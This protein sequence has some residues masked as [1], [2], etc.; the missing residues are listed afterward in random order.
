M[1]DRSSCPDFRDFDPFR[2]QLFP[3]E[4]ENLSRHIESCPRC[5]RVV[6]ELMAKDTL[7]EGVS[8]DSA[9]EG[10]V[11]NA[12]VKTLIARL[13]ARPP[14]V[15][16]PSDDPPTVELGEAES[17]HACRSSSD[18][19]AEEMYDFLRPAL[20]SNRPVPF[21][22]YRVVGVLGT[23][24]M[25]IVLKAEDPQL[26]RPV[27]I[28]VLNPLLASNAMA[29]R[30]FL[31][32]ARAAAAL[33]HDHI[34]PIYHVGT[35]RG[36]PYLVMPMLSGETL[37]QRFRREGS[38]PLAEILR[39]GREVAAGLAAAHERGLVHRD[40][41]PS[42]LWLEAAGPEGSRPQG[43]RPR[44][45]SGRVRI[46]DFGLA[47]VEEEDG[48]L[49][50]EGHP[51]GTPAYMAPEQARGEKVGPGADLFSLGCIL[52]RL[53]TGKA[54]FRGANSRMLFRSLEEHLPRAP[55]QLNPALPA[56]FSDLLLR[57]LAKE[58]ADRPASA[59]EVVRDIA[60]IEQ[61]LAS[62]EPSSQRPRRR[63]RAVLAGVATLVLLT[64][65]A[66]GYQYAPSIYRL[67][68]DQG[69][70]V[71]ET[72]E[73]GVEVVIKDGTGRVIDHAGKREI[74]L[75]AGTYEVDCRLVDAGGEQQFLTKHL[76][77]RR[78]ERIVLDAR[79]E[80]AKLDL[81]GPA[82]KALRTLEAR[83]ANSS[84]DRE[85][86]R[87]QLLTFRRNYAGTPFGQRASE[88]LS[89]LTS[90]LDKLSAD[91]IP[92][93]ERA[94]AGGKQAPHELVAVLGSSS[95]G[96]WHEVHSVAFSP[97]GK[98]LAS[99][100]ADW[101]VKVWHVQN[102][103]ELHTLA[104]HQGYVNGVAFSPDG[105]TLASASQDGTVRIWD[106]ASG[107]ELQVLRGG[108]AGLSSVAFHRDGNLLASGSA[109]GS[110][111][112]WDPASG[113]ELGRLIGHTG[114]VYA[115]AFHPQGELLASASADRTVRL[116]D[117]RQFRG[118]QEQKGRQPEVSSQIP[119]RTLTGHGDIVRSVAFS[120]DG[121]LLASGSQDGTIL[122]WDVPQPAGPVKDTQTK[123]GVLTPR[124]LGKSRDVQA[125]AFSSDG[126]SLVTGT[127][128]GEKAE[129]WDIA[130][131]AVRYSVPMGHGC[132][133]VAFSPDDKLLAGGG[134][135]AA[136]HI[137]EPRMTSDGKT[138]PREWP[139]RAGL[140]PSGH[141]GIVSSVAFS[142]DGSTLA[143][144]GWD[145]TV[146]LCDC[147]S[148]Q[149][150]RALR[151]HQRMVASV[152]FSPDGKVLASSA[153][154]GSIRLWDSATGEKLPD[155]AGHP[156]YVTCLAFHPSGQF[157][158]S[159]SRDL[160]VKVW[161]LASRVEHCTL[162]S[163]EKLVR[164]LAYS[165]DGGSLASAGADST[166]ILRETEHFQELRRLTGHQGQVLALAYS[167]DNSILASAGAD[168]TVRLWDPA[169][170][171]TL[172]TLKGHSS[173]VTSVSFR[174]DGRVLATSADDGT[175]RLWN[176]KL[177]TAGIVFHL[178]P[179]GSCIKQVVFSPGGRHL[180]AANANGTVYI[181]RVSTAPGALGQEV[182]EARPSA[183]ASPSSGGNPPRI[184]N[185]PADAERSAAQWALS[186]GA[187]GKILVGG[188]REDLALA[189][190][191]RAG[192]FQVV[193]LIFGP[194]AKLS[195]SELEHLAT[196][197]SLTSLKLQGTWVSDSSLAQLKGLRNLHRLDLVA[198]RVSD[199]GLAH[200]NQLTNLDHLI[201]I[202]VPV[203]DSGLAHLRA[204]Q[205]L[206]HLALGFT[207]VTEAGMDHVASL[208]NLTGWLTLDNSK[209]TDTWLPHLTKLSGLAGLWLAR[210]PIGDAGLAS[211]KAFPN[212]ED[213]NL[214]YTK[215]GD[216]GLVHVTSLRKL[217][218][219]HLAGTGV[220]DAGL[221]HL[222]GLS[223]LQE[224]DLTKTK[225]TASG[226][227]ELQKALPR[228]HIL[229][230]P[231]LAPGK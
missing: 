169:T 196:F 38:L 86:L 39:I 74:L 53:S 44:G 4:L 103:R 91:K 182:A 141:R 56:A 5:A 73:P 131:G 2:G 3:E 146:R 9:A 7:M 128:S 55:R 20:Q 138:A 63:R 147:A 202:D 81:S 29:G 194:D 76:Q 57:L 176:P 106:V 177:G 69:D 130:A 34:V 113:K 162:R 92:A 188:K 227:A 178:A 102:G 123:P 185:E 78:G 140:D 21:G 93:N 197:P 151:G 143:S 220:S 133:T 135:D 48:Q 98:L 145:E 45:S 226:V 30:R 15:D 210:N 172:H 28:K 84:V 52:Y 109:D 168:G 157:L 207:R 217:K 139:V 163:H 160:T 211:L 108:R 222:R 96:H 64:L 107:R 99:A 26:G 180:A 212:L 184:A 174:G 88:L 62:Q 122:L 224:L 17:K 132:K 82:D 193:N 11:R 124:V 219:L 218:Q 225:V 195:D 85:K 42:N 41:K 117:R 10:W 208:P 75:K 40:I 19:A 97:D 100:S 216:A 72:N 204:N 221:S 33:T 161:E 190:E 105:R 187:K 89:S 149:E 59:E 173:W 66:L 175:I 127:W 142:P 200:L 167:P 35:D 223:A 129:V 79:M 120:H 27:A 171:K 166:I 228:C 116:W 119:A 181:L 37:E 215:V 46:L 6:E 61:S 148:G 25:A 189:L 22:P 58:A 24:G 112:L 104:R 144:G 95:L 229:F 50:H 90:P 87:R 192:A 54:P 110:V 31:R 68:T 213:L 71:I 206:H 36:V 118:S 43:S 1:P 77:I 203:T 191:E 159:A 23:G 126:R 115:V 16:P 137:W 136:V 13:S 152:V 47:R 186:R 170:G 150:L 198:A 230:E 94:S 179:P 199:A 70:L 101:S 111:M 164:C 121:R 165:S 214:S 205:K 155:L 67:V 14:W 231:E 134:F 201:L 8:G 153:W 18:P 65:A 51:I 114:E 60:A 183:E 49:S 158:A 83:A 154:N 209:V 156:D 80:P 32:E 125:L 12:E